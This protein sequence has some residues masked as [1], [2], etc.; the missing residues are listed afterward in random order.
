MKGFPESSESIQRLAFK[1]P[2]GAC[3]ARA[4]MTLI[5]EAEPGFAGTWRSNGGTY[6]GHHA[7][8][9][10]YSVEVSLEGLAG[11]PKRIQLVGVFAMY[12]ESA[13]EATGTIGATVQILGDSEILFRQDLIN[14][15]HYFD[16]T[17]LAP[18]EQITGDGTSLQTIGSIEVDGEPQR[19]D[20]LTLDI[21]KLV[22]ARRMIIRDLGSPASFVIAEI[23]V[24]PDRHVACP[25]HSQSGQIPLREVAAIVRVGDR[26][27]F[28]K[29][30]IQLE[31]GIKA[32]QDLDEARGQALTFI[33]V[34][35]AGMLE[36]GG[37][38]ELHRIQLTAAR[39]LETLNTLEEVAHAALEISEQIAEPL[40]STPESPTAQLVDRALAIVERNFAKN[41]TD[42]MVAEQLGLSTSHFRFLFRQATGNPF[43]KYLIAV[44]LEK[45]RQMLSHQDLPV[46][47]VANAVGFTGL[48]HFSRAFA[49]R[50]SM[51]PSSVRRVAG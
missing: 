51:S 4:N 16:A 17:N 12:A 40:F 44:R 10:P 48:S 37:S 23:L 22:G 28:Q 32:A 11:P 49:Q 33:A 20:V 34:V 18:I 39:R 6:R 24:E 25:F 8:A 27:R 19:L 38:R 15:R 31:S 41:L 3:S 26:R 14:G 13:Q 50:F 29:V 42:S 1:R 43:H 45:A 7:K 47:H 5:Q 46:S 35:T 2:Y 30:L 9:Y 36:S 21:P